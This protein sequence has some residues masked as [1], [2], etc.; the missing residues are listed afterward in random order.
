MKEFLKGPE[1]HSLND[2][3][4]PRKDTKL[5][6]VSMPVFREQGGEGWR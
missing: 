6:S 1:Y 5:R 4:E 3:G 2:R